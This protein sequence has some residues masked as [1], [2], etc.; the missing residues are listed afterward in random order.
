MIHSNYTNPNVQ[1]IAMMNNNGFNNN[2]QSG[3]MN[4]QSGFTNQQSGFVGNTGNIWG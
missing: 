1:G 2:M 3:F 4:Q